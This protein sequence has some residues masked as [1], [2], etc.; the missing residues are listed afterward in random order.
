MTLKLFRII[1]FQ[2]NQ[3]DV[4]DE[5]AHFAKRLITEGMRK[6]YVTRMNVDLMSS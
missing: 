3:E 5:R 4:K 2:W 6:K 1:S